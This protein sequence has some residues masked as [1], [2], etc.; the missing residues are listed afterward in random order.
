MCF[1]GRRKSNCT[2]TPAHAI[3]AP[4]RLSNKIKNKLTAQELRAI[5][6]FCNLLKEKAGNSIHATVLFGSRARG[7]GHE[8]SDVDI[9][10][11]L[12]E[13]N[14][15][16]KIKIWDYAYAI[17][18]ETD[19]I[20]SPLVLSAAQFKKLLSHERLIAMTIQKEGIKL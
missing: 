12:N 13:E 15:P 14:H 1:L 9:L 17:F 8:N 7:E 10:V 16:L 11:I 20:I 4:V 2:F 18:N 6:L 19:I 5:S 3:K